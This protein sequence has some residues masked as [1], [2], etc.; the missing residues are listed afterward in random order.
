MV[1]ARGGTASLRASSSMATG[2]SSESKQPAAAAA[3]VTSKGKRVLRLRLF[4]KQSSS[5]RIVV[6]PAA[7]AKRK[8][9]A[10]RAQLLPAK[11]Q[12]PRK[13]VRKGLLA[14]SHAPPTG[15]TADEVCDPIGYLLSGLTEEQTT[16]I[17]ATLASGIMLWTDY[18]DS[19]QAERAVSSLAS[20]ILGPEANSVHL[21]RAC[22]IDSSCQRFLQATYPGMCV[23]TDILQ[24]MPVDLK[25]HLEAMLQAHYGEFV[26]AKQAAL[27]K[28][29]KFSKVCEEIGDRFLVQAAAAL[30]GSPQ[31]ESLTVDCVACEKHCPAYRRRCLE[32]GQQGG[33][34]MLIAGVSCVDWS[35]RGKQ[36][37]I[38]G[39][40]SL[41][42]LT[43]M[44]EILHC[45]YA[46]IVLECTERFR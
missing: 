41:P 9:R 17:K 42:F 34:K 28:G 29:E 25:A 44:Y 31:Q 1:L 2:G 38:L 12:P 36:L 43:L 37:G 18:S 19:G 32:P 16:A 22:D 24:R 7:T 3:A 11:R 33:I 26:E 35:A 45:R 6:V 4:G 5:R 27:A 39:P 46:I 20:A 23:F 8:P 14:T 21:D 13:G 10:R 15:P 30:R 40:T